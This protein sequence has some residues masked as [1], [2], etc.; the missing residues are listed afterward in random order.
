ME[1]PFHICDRLAFVRELKKTRS[2]HE[3]RREDE[4]KVHEL[5]SSLP[6]V[7]KSRQHGE[8]LYIGFVE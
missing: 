3:G 7:S 6:R 2:H 5:R 1:R 8:G 4:R